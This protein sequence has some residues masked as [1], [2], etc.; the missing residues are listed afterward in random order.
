MMHNHGPED[1]PGLACN[2]VRQ[3]DGALK[4]ACLLEAPAPDPTPA[5]L[6]PGELAWAEHS[7]GFA[8]D[9]EA[10]QYG[11]L[12]AFLAGYEAAQRSAPSTSALERL[13]RLAGEARFYARLSAVPAS[14][15]ALLREISAVVGRLNRSQVR[16]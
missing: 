2:E 9:S 7:I 8:W 1:G 3:P 16:A 6:T 15:Q 12:R 11:E 10:H 13:T 4:G 5:A 14:T